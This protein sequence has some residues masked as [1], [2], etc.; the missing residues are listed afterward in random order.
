MNCLADTPEIFTVPLGAP[1]AYN[2]TVDSGDPTGYTV[3]AKLKP[4]DANAT[5][6]PDASVASVADFG[7]TFVAASG[8]VKAYWILSISA[9]VCKTL[10]VG[11]FAADEKFTLAGEVKAVG[12]PAV[13]IDIVESVSG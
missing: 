6:A 9:A 8:A 12:Y 11:R 1:I 3:S 7:V 4:I 2:V 10:G 5:T 13:I